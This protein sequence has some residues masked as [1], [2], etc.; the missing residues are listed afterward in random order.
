MKGVNY[1][2][3]GIGSNGK[4]MM[5]YPNQE[6][7]FGG[8]QYVDEYPMMGKGGEMIRRAD[9]SYSRRGLWDNIRANKGSGKKPTKDMLEQEKKIKAKNM[10]NGG[11][12]NAGFDALP[13]Y[14]QA[15]ILSN[16]GYGGYYNP[17][18]AIGGEPNG[19]MALGQMMAVAD[20]MS[21]LREFVS[22]DQNL[23]PWIAS[24]LATMDD[25]AA[26]ISDYMMYNPEAQEMQEM[27]NGGYTVTRSNDRKGKTHKVTGPDGTVKY[28]G[29][30]KLGQH[31][32]DPE[33][34]KAFYARHKKNLAGNP[35]FRAFAR[36]TWEDGGST[37]SGNAFYQEGGEPQIQDYAD[38]NSYMA[39]LEQYQPTYNIEDAAQEMSPRWHSEWEEQGIDPQSMPTASS[40]KLKDYKGVSVVDFL[41]SQG[42]NKTDY[43]SRKEL[44]K[45]LGISNYRGTAAQNMQLM[46]TLKN[47]PDTLNAYD[48]KPVISSVGN[49][50]AVNTASSSKRAVSGT[51][52]T[53]PNS[54]APAM[55]PSKANL[56]D[57]INSGVS[58]SL[59]SAQQMAAQRSNQGSFSQGKGPNPY[60]ASNR[61]PYDD[62][63][64]LNKIDN[65]PRSQANIRKRN[66]MNFGKNLAIGTLAPW[67]AEGALMAATTRYLPYGLTELPQVVSAARQAS[68]ALPYATRALP[69]QQGGE[70]M[71]VTPEQAEEL[72]RQGY[73]FEIL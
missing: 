38:Y 61:D 8:S 29:D 51:P 60:A 66:A 6:Y 72:R 4:S 13:E 71:D 59:I 44:A 67:L 73:Q 11:T 16:M 32:R 15:K 9:G 64:M 48:S 14:V 69:F 41:A 45:S 54:S 10:K 65:D 37:F 21:K 5:M 28:F 23:D 40:R 50:A 17:M 62:S 24:K 56:M 57:L 39:A 68:K 26:A 31:P 53:L 33:R 3:L 2:V 18:M 30:S 58:P 35:F 52:R 43:A 22:P 47:S 49:R 27:G 63:Y 12:N 70:I 25:S 19:S 34:K 42:M 7:S 20:K 36:K 1:P 55:I 46:Q